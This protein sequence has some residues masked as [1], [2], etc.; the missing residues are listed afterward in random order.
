VRFQHLQRTVE[1]RGGVASRNLACEK[2][3]YPAQP[4][5]C[6]LVD[7]ELPVSPVLIPA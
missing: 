6:V 4:V 5:M 1:D 2:R 7:R 3:L